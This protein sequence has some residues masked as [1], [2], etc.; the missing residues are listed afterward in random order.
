MHR[1]EGRSFHISYCLLFTSLIRCIPHNIT[2]ERVYVHVNVC[3]CMCVCVEYT[4]LQH[5]YREFLHTMPVG[6]VI[7][8]DNVRR[9]T[10]IRTIYDYTSQIYTHDIHIT[11][12][13]IHIH[14][15]YPNRRAIVV[16]IEP[17]PVPQLCVCVCM[18]TCKYTS[19]YIFR[20]CSVGSSTKVTVV[21]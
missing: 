3:I 14:L 13:Y 15:M 8:C 18:S 17:R 20:G 2:S 1:E 12:I 11:N 10:S 6:R 9:T 16:I 5:I 21:V 19:V 7:G 4:Y